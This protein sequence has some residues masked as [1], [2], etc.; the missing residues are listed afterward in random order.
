MDERD[1]ITQAIAIVFNRLKAVQKDE[2]AVWI[3]T[4][5]HELSQ[6]TVIANSPKDVPEVWDWIWKIIILAALLL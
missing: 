4:F 6:E 1:K 2:A 5:D 3:S